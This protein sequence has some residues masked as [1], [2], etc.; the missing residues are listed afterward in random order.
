LVIVDPCSG[1]D[2]NAAIEYG[3]KLPP[4]RDALK[5]KL[6][7]VMRVYLEKPRTTE[8][9]THREMA[10]G[11]SMPVGFKNGADGGSTIAGCCQ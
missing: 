10:S 8:S 2:V 7:I 9:Q 5:D 4:L 6:E 3:K 11:L 1:H